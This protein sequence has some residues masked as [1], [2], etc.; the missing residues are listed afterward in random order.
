MKNP[1]VIEGKERL[2]RLFEKVNAYNED[3]E[4]KAHLVQYLCVQVSGFIE[5]S[6][7]AILIDY[8]GRKGSDQYVSN[9]VENQLQRSIQ[10]PN[11]DTILQLIRSFNANWEVCLRAQVTEEMKSSIGSIRSNR[12]QIAHGV[13]VTI[14][15]APT[16]RY[17]QDTVAVIELIEQQ[18]NL[19]SV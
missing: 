3:E 11:V 6:V 7:R 9:F 18:C 2:D 8:A 14:S 17:Y 5:T 1:T 15:Y 19:E 13:S 12:N 10:N 4:L 16:R